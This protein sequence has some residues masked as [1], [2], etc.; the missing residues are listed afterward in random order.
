MKCLWDKLVPDAAYAIWNVRSLT[1]VALKEQISTPLMLEALESF[2]TLTIVFVTS[3]TLF[4]NGLL[5]LD[6][7]D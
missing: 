5:V 6:Y 4:K 1:S 3:R 7:K 2:T